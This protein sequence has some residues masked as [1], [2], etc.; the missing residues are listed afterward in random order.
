MAYWNQNGGWQTYAYPTNYKT[1]YSA[2][3]FAGSI[4]NK[5]AADF[6]KDYAYKSAADFPAGTRE[7]SKTYWFK[8]VDGEVVDISTD[9]KTGD[10][11]RSKTLSGTGTLREQWGDFVD[12][13]NENQKDRFRGYKQTFAVNATENENDRTRAAENYNA[14]QNTAREN[15]AK[16]WNENQDKVVAKIVED[17]NKQNSNLNLKNS[18]INSWSTSIK[19]KLSS[20]R[21]GTYA[22]TLSGLDTSVLDSL[23]QKKLITDQEY[24]TLVDT[25]VNSFD[26][27]YL[28]N[29]VSAW[30]ARSKGAQPPVGGFDA[31]YYRTKTE[32][33]KTAQQ[34][35]NNA[36][37][38]VNVNG[39]YLP[40]LDITARYNRDTYLHWY[41]TTQ[42]K[43]AGERGNAAQSPGITEDYKEYLT[44]ADYQ[45]YRD[46]VLGLA[47][48]FDN[49]EDWSA[50]QDPAVLREWYNSLSSDQKR[51]YDEG[52][53]DVP[54]LD[55]IPDRLRD[56]IKMTKGTTY[57]EGGL[58]GILGEKEKEQQAIFASLT[59]DSL[60][61]A[62][63]QLRLAKQK[64]QAFDMYASLPGLNEVISVNESLSNSL[65]GDSGIGGV[66]G[67]M[68]DPE[69]VQKGLES[70]LEKATGIPSRSNAVYNWQKW[71]EDELVKSYETGATVKDP[72]DPNK[73]YTIDADFAKDYIDRYLKPR[74]DT[75]RSMSEFISYMDIKQNE[76]NV[77]QTQSAFDALRDIADL[78]AKAYLDGV[79][80]AT[81]LN[82]NADFYWDPQGNFTADDPKAAK[83]AEQKN[84]LT[85]DWEEAKTRGSTALVPGTDRT[86]DQWAYYYGLD[87][88]DK[89]QFAKLHYQVKGAA[90]GFDPAR[91]LITL[92][93]ANDY[94][95]NTILPEITDE[96]LNIGDI[97]FLNFVTP[98]EFADRLLEGIDPAQNKEEWD[99]LLE[100]LGL[101]SKD[102]GIEEVKN[103]VID[104]FRTG[105]AKQI[106]ESIKY[107]NEK[108]ITPSQEELGVEYI[109]RPEDVKP[110]SSPYETDL[111][112]VFKN[113]GYQGSE[114]DFYTQFMPDIDRGEMELLSK[115]GKGLELSG[116]YA[117][118]TS[119]DPFEAL[120][121]MENLFSTADK[122]ETGSKETA[123][124]YFKLFED[125]TKDQDYKSKSGQ[126]ILGEFTSFFKGFT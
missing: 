94:I 58:S 105:A 34:E 16:E 101:S 119:K 79:K 44:D 82:F 11:W 121:S 117:G 83:Y 29:Y 89:N 36:Q 3:D 64:E 55:Y 9:P 88:R 13:L 72:L 51:E 43:A 23:K 78:R 108:K 56:K 39:R 106:R 109:E 74:F 24:N 49:I 75:S 66:L 54:T 30:D 86:W 99:K 69:K 85:R 81:P 76:Q 95:Q 59:S 98:E 1:D 15:A 62:A 2:N 112:K 118:L 111:Y 60:K 14:Q 126:K 122:M 27:F 114:D 5:T 107:L 90:R 97:T 123:P 53:L 17:T 84:E 52:V 61:K 4:T 71:F 102:M 125:E 41:Y 46:E 45:K 104:A 91:D 124:S 20:A 73:T 96:K 19:N 103:Y 116:A 6:A 48:R 93:D 120:A 92:K 40:D 8:V 33:G 100:T 12:K 68:S 7:T 47:D 110:T 35:W 18:S 38:A 50:A 65:L 113:A 67:W 32:G 42:G 10:A 37:T 22:R 28:K 63:N 80:S 87:V 115:S 21:E 70:S 57:L 26:T 25:A 31:D 77:F